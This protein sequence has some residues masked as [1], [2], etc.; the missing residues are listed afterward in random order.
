MI[1]I[2]N[3]K[4]AGIGPIKDLE[5]KFDNHFNIEVVYT[6]SFLQHSVQSASH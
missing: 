5:L 6:F 2:N 3:I 1:K 4:I